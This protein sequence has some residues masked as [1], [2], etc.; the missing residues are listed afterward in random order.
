MTMQTK[1]VTLTFKRKEL[2]YDIKNNCYIDAE[3]PQNRPDGDMNEAHD[4]HQVQ[5]VGD[6]GNVD[7]VTRVLDLTFAECVELCF[8]YTKAEV[9]EDISHDDTMHES[10][11]VMVMNVSEGFSQTTVNLLV[12]SIHELMVDKVVADWMS[13][14]K[15]DSFANWQTKAE[16]A[17]QSV[18]SMLNARTR[19]V[20][21]KM[22]PF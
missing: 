3:A 2:L 19:P 11:Y 8:P 16:A 9:V 15:P 20:R 10:D 7:R 1:K 13:I 12:K 21:R 4:R 5:A 22:R 17:A 6:D 18:V 14:N